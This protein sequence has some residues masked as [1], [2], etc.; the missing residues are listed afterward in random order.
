MDQIIFT[1]CMVEA[2]GK[3]G[4]EGKQGRSKMV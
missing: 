1:L 2:E 3:D 4:A